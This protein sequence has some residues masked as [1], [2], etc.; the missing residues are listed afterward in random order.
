[1]RLKRINLYN[2]QVNTKN[3]K[4][5]IFKFEIL[6]SQKKYV[7]NPISPIYFPNKYA[8]A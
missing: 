3:P 1:M 8:N 7:S 4:Y 5:A 2:M 6:I